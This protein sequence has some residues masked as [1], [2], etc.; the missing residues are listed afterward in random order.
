MG[1]QPRSELGA[2]AGHLAT[3]KVCTQRFG[4]LRYLRDEPIGFELLAELRMRAPSAAGLHRLPLVERL[5][6][7]H[8]R[9]LLFLSIAHSQDLKSLITYETNGTDHADQFLKVVHGSPSQIKKTRLGRPGEV[10]GNRLLLG[11]VDCQ[12]ARAAPDFKL[13]ICYWGAL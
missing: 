5:T 11:S 6:Y 13:W 3:R 10:Q 2:N 12:H 1:D 9:Y 8:Q 7:S 4:L